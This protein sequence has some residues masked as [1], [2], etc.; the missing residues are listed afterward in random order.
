MLTLGRDVVERGREGKSPFKMRC[1]VCGGRITAKGDCLNPGCQVY[2]IKGGYKGRRGG[3]GR[4][5][6]CSS[7]RPKPLSNEE[8]RTLMEPY[9]TP[10]VERLLNQ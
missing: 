3:P 6:W 9:L 4:I 1:P 10:S 5:V 7:P 2:K 8:L